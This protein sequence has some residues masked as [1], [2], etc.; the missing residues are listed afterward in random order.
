MAK[1]R[2]IGL[3]GFA[4]QIRPSSPTGSY[5][6]ETAEH[7]EPCESRGSCTKRAELKFLRATRQSRQIDAVRATSALAPGP[8]EMVHHGECRIG[9]AAKGRMD[10]DRFS[11]VAAP[12]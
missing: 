7:R 12:Y 11:K 8:V 3:I 6:M 10:V 9:L 1:A 2:E 4:A 5:V